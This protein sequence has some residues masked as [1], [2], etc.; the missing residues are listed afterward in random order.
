MKDKSKILQKEGETLFNNAKTKNDYLKA[1]EKFDEAWKVY[2]NE[3]SLQKK[4]IE[5]EC[6]INIKIAEDYFN[7]KEYIKASNEYNKALTLA[8]SGNLTNLINK[9]NE[10]I[11]FYRKKNFLLWKIIKFRTNFK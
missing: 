11:I 6:W 9:S 4:I 5:T 3:E 10:F 2:N 7:S 8:K 1:K